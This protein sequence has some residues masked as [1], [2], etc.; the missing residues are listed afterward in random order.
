MALATTPRPHLS[1]RR[2]A[3]ALTISAGIALGGIVGV[4]ARHQLSG[5]HARAASA[6]VSVT[7]QRGGLGEYLQALAATR[8]ENQSFGRAIGGYAEQLQLLGAASAP[9]N[10]IAAR[11]LGGYADFVRGQ[12]APAPTMSDGYTRP[13][14]GYAEW[15]RFQAE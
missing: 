7:D 15:L 12:G 13:V 1:A 4:Q 2:M 5:T 6:H 11:P 8:A 14:G 3:I 9:A 10:A